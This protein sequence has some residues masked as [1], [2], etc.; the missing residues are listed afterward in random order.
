MNGA[1]AG[2]QKLTSVGC[3]G[4]LL[5]PVLSKVFTSDLDSGVECTNLPMT[6]N[7]EVMITL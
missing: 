5:G 1:T 3:Q 6:V 4:S 2:W 7:P